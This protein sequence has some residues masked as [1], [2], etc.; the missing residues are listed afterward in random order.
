MPL[1]VNSLLCALPDI[2]YAYE[3]ISINI[4]IVRYK[5]FSCTF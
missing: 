2:F 1:T 5:K 3:N 4:Y